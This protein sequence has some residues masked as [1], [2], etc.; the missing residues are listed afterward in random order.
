MNSLKSKFNPCL[1]FCWLWF[2]QESVQMSWLW[3]GDPFPSTPSLPLWPHLSPVPNYEPCT[4][5]TWAFSGFQR[6]LGSF[7]TMYF[8]PLPS[9]PS[10][11]NFYSSFK[12]QLPV[13][14]LCHTFFTFPRES[15]R[16]RAP[17][18]FYPD[19]YEKV[20]WAALK[21]VCV[22]K[23]VPLHLLSSTTIPLFVHLFTH[24]S[25]TYWG[26]TLLPRIV[27]GTGDSAIYKIPSLLGAAILVL[28]VWVY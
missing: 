16:S 28:R 11:A 8:V 22:C 10:L 20:G 12:T 6:M 7:T 9:I 13:V 4:S 17:I 1:K 26:P 18:A 14:L 15:F 3:M 2:L 5:A 23:P 19:P 24:S 27:P 25:N 21:N